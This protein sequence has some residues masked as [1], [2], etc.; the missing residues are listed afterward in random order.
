MNFDRW[1][2]ILKVR[3]SSNTSN[4]KLKIDFNCY[5]ITFVEDYSEN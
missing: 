4:N 3:K 5:I 2:E 1:D